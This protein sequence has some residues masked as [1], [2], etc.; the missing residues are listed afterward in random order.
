[1][2]KKKQNQEPYKRPNNINKIFSDKV[3]LKKT[4]ASNAINEPVTASNNEKTTYKDCSYQQKERHRIEIQNRLSN[5]PDIQ[6]LIL[7]LSS[8]S[9]C[10]GKKRIKNSI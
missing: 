4:K 2:G 1:M 8:I 10:L 9:L 6:S 5:S 7:Y 3:L